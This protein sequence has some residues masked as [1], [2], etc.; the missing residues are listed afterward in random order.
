MTQVYFIMTDQKTTEQ[1][2]LG[3]ERSKTSLFLK[4]V[5]HA[6]LDLP[7]NN[8]MISGLFEDF[9]WK[10]VCSEHRPERF[11]DEIQLKKHFADVGHKKALQ[12]LN[13]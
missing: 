13:K 6:K 10:F 11:M 8:D 3:L 12:S 7:A 4:R 2:E 5:T 1:I 9:Q